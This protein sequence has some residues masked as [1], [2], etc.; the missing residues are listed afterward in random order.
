MAQQ[1]GSSS[2]ARYVQYTYQQVS[3]LILPTRSRMLRRYQHQDELYTSPIANRHEQGGGRR[4]S[5]RLINQNGRS[6]R[7]TSCDILWFKDVCQ[8]CVGTRD[9]CDLPTQYSGAPIHF[10]TSDFVSSILFDLLLVVLLL[11][12]VRTGM[13]SRAGPKTLTPSNRPKRLGL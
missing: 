11:G 9:S 2:M 7:G 8:P 4:Q 1:H 12:R 13:T 6:R 10:E 5:A 3:I